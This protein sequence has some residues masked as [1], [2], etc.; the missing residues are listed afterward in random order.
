MDCRIDVITFFQVS[1]YAYYPVRPEFIINEIH[2]A[3]TFLVRKQQIFFVLREG[4][5]QVPDSDEPSLQRCL[6]KEVFVFTNY[7]FGHT[8]ACPLCDPF[9][10]PPGQAAFFNKVMEKQ[11]TQF[12][13]QR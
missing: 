3:L 10:K 5:S 7:Y 1:Y 12:M 13:L 6:F 11:V 4:M 2:N 8:A 9:I